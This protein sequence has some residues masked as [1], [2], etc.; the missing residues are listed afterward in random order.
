MRLSKACSNLLAV[1]F[2]TP[3]RAVIIVLSPILPL[4]F[5]KFFQISIN[6][7]VLV[8]FLLAIISGC[9]GLLMGTIDFA[10]LFLY[11]WICFPIIYLLLGD[12]RK[13]GRG[14][15]WDALFNSIRFWLMIVN[16]IGFI[17]RFFIFKTIDDFG[18]AYG[19]HFKGVSGLCVVNAFVALYYLSNMLKGIVTRGIICNFLFF[20]CSFIFCYSGLTLITFIATLFLFFLFNLKL[21][22][23][24]KIFILLIIGMFALIYSSRNILDYNIRN[25]ELFLDDDDAQGNA[26]KRVMYGNFLDLFRAEPWISVIGVGP[27]GYNSRIC[28]LLNDDSENI[29]TSVLGHHMPEYHKADIYPLW[30][31]YIVSFDS[32]TDGAR[33]KPFSS[34]VATCVETGA[35]FFI[36]FSFFWF[37]KMNQYRKWSEVDS[38]YL[39]LFLLNVFVYL[40]LITEYWFESSEFVLFL[41]LQNSLL[42]NKFSGLK[43]DT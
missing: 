1:S 22:N 11:V 42:S 28:F 23:V 14:I 30:N 36:L 17:C 21:K 9:F 41:I 32:Y 38:D 20:F 37:K 18:W 39:Y 12:V 43:Y 8:L 27:G 40:L 16:V 25:I 35:V 31:K 7:K 33:N 4:L 2:L 10:N 29:F 34:L 15:S 6:R 3:L 5:A 26:R 13:G 24:L 19:E